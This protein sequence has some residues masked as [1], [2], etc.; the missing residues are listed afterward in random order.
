MLQ[1][2]FGVRYRHRSKECSRMLQDQHECPK[3]ERAPTRFRNNRQKM[4]QVP[5]NV[6]QV[7]AQVQKP[8]RD[9]FDAEDA[10]STNGTKYE[11]ERKYD[12]FSSAKTDGAL[13]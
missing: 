2:T 1:T 3:Y 13:R 5:P 4:D 6:D 12:C 8:M 9:G 7:K 10:S 11:T